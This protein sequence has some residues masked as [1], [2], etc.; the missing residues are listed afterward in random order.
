MRL[1]LAGSTR[2]V[3][4]GD[5]GDRAEMILVEIARGDGFV[6]EVEAHPD[7]RL[8]DDEILVPAAGSRCLV[9]L[10]ED[11]ERAELERGAFRGHLLEALVV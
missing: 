4:V 9:E 5:D 1:S 2:A 8:A 3:L 11:A 10:G 7:R 6:A